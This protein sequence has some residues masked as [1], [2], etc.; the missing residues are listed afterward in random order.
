MGGNPSSDKDADGSIET[1]FSSFNTQIQQDV[2]TML[3][4][5]D[6]IVNAGSMSNDA[7]LS[8]GQIFTTISRRVTYMQKQLT[9]AQIK[10]GGGEG[11]V[12]AYAFASTKLGKFRDFF[13]DIEW[14]LSDIKHSKH[15][16]WEGN[17]SNIVKSLRT[18][19]KTGGNFTHILNQVA[20]QKESLEPEPPSF[21]PKF[22]Q[23]KSDR[24]GHRDETW[25]ARRIKELE[26]RL[27]AIDKQI[28]KV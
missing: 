26:V 20:T 27:Q 5:L 13:L 10:L 19:M 15:P 1:L 8:L 25:K 4:N 28:R 12:A 14:T 2:D 22:K 11:P 21:S 6:D 9:S 23:P 7:E 17:V 16:D 24:E 3:T 18:F